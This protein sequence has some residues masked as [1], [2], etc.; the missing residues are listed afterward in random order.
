MRRVYAQAAIMMLF[1]F[2]LLLGPSCESASDVHNPG[3]AQFELSVQH[4]GGAVP[5]TVTFE[6][7]LYGDIE[8]L[9]MCVP[10]Y[11]FCPGIDAKGCVWYEPLCDSIQGARRSYVQTFIYQE[12]GTYRAVMRL[13]CENDRWTFIDTVVVDVQ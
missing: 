7:R 10:D 5:D 11:S 9:H 12:S 6:G 3:P 4:A 8:G 1:C 2:S 13:F